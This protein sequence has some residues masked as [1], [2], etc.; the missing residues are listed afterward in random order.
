MS[1]TLILAIYGAVSGSVGTGVAWRNRRDSIWGRRA[2]S[3]NIR[4][5]L[6]AI[7]NTMTEA[8]LAPSSAEA[9]TGTPI[10]RS[11]LQEV[12]EQ[13]KRGP[14]RKMRK[15]LTAVRAGCLA[16][17]QYAP[18]GGVA[19]NSASYSLVSAIDAT[20]KAIGEALGRLDLI[21]RRSPS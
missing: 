6:D 13:A 12:E 2:R 8:K 14:D 16:V 15:L 11:H 17:I 1:A 18:S 9:L 5:S 21:D 19:S 20:Q 4:P 7:R 3:R 10:F